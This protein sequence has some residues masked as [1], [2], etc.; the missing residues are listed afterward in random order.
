V[1]RSRTA[2]KE[3]DERETS[4]ILN[5]VAGVL[6]LAAALFALVSFVSFQQGRPR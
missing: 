1:G 2:A 6:T 4:Q 3:A 5:E